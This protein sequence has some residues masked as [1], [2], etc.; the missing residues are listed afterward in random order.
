MNTHRRDHQPRYWVRDNSWHN[1]LGPFTDEDTAIL[2][3]KMVNHVHGGVKVSEIFNQD[4]KPEDFKAMDNCYT[5]YSRT[6]N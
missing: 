6:I 3:S 2:K 4:T 1:V 5:P